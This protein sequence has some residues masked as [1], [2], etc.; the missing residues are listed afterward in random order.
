MV[1]PV[2]SSFT[3]IHAKPSLNELTDSLIVNDL[4]FE[5]P[6]DLLSEPAKLDPPQPGYSVVGK[7]PSF[8]RKMDSKKADALKHRKGKLLLMEHLSILQNISL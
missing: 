2:V 4:P 6:D 3:V 7:L 1:T 5:E 8:H